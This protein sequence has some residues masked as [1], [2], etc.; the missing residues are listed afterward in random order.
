MI[1]LSVIYS[2]LWLWYLQRSK[3]I[4]NLHLGAVR[5]FSSP[6]RPTHSAR[7]TRAL[8]PVFSQRHLHREEAPTLAG[9]WALP[10]VLRHFV[11]QSVVPPR[12]KFCAAHGAVEI[13]PW[14]FVV[15]LFVFLSCVVAHEHHRAA[16][17]RAADPLFPALRV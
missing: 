6:F 1:S 9:V 16:R 2:C 8:F 13:H 17:E 3:L 12:K 15:R 5:V 4:H 10:P 14:L 7:P 11:S